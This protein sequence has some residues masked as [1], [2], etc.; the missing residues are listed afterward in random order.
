MAQTPAEKAAADAAAAAA[1]QAAAQAAAAAA[2]AKAAAEAK[3]KQE[4]ENAGVAAAASFGISQALLA[5]HPELVAVYNMFKAGNTA[6]ATEALYATDYYKNSSSTVKQRE[7]QKLEQPA[8][9][10]DSLEKYKIAARQRLVT[11]GIKIDVAAFDLLAADAYAKGMD[12]N[13]FDQ[14]IM[15]SGKITGFGGNILGDTTTLK[16]Y[17]SSFG[18]DKYLDAN[19]WTQKQKDLFMGTITANDIEK[20]IRDKAASAFPGYAD[21]INNGVTVDSIASAYKGAMANLL[22]RDADSI[23]Y[24]DPRLRAA[25]QYV[26]PDGKP[27]TKPLWQFEKELRSSPEWQYTNNARNTVDSM[28][29]KVLQDWG[30]M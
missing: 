6:G 18:V 2:A 16:A 11:T 1:A 4:L 30:M 14:A 17:A 22:E 7:K 25:L 12:D 5:A 20:E 28:S 24:D 13:Q 10:A 19:Y 9:Y 3:A 23:T 8:V 21:Q 15:V 26:G 27:S 29:L